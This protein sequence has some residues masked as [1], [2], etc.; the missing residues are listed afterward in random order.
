M[1]STFVQW[2]EATVKLTWVPGAEVPDAGLVTSVHG[3]CM[4]GEELL[5]VNLD[6]RGWDIPG[7]RIEG[8]EDPE[9]CFKREAM[10]EGYVSGQCRLLGMS[11]LIIRI[12][13]HG[14]RK[15]HIPKSG[16]RFIT[17]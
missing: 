1:I 13:P 16:I 5:L 10:E 9:T 4:Q 17:K 6:H 15:T 12:I 3:M 7:G 11:L 14:Q 2:G 8:R